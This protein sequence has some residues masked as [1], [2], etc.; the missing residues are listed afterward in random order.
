MNIT[1]AYLKRINSQINKCEKRN[2]IYMVAIGKKYQDEAIMLVNSLRKIGL[3]NG[4]IICIT[5]SLFNIGDANI[6]IIKEQIIPHLIRF[7]A[8]KLINFIDY[9]K[10]M[11]LD[12]DILCQKPINKL[13]N[14]D[15]SLHY[16]EEQWNDDKNLIN[17]D[18]AEALY[19]K[20]KNGINSG[21]FCISGHNINEFLYKWKETYEKTLDKR[22]F[23]RYY[24]QASFNYIIR[25]N[26][27][28]NTQWDIGLIGF[29]H[30]KIDYRSGII[31]HYTINK[32][33]MI[34]DYVKLVFPGD[35]K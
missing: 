25:K 19:W 5:N 14:N 32:K 26:L 18:T 28:K 12:T 10:V 1:L 34:K 13:F 20:N 27:I 22:Y 16:T 11:Y 35:H 21:T 7:H 15:G 3:F 33:L 24:D 29:P 30:N 4:E 31:A 9:D 23:K 2:L 8:Y 6:V 17:F